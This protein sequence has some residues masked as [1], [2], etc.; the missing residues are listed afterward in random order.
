MSGHS[1][2]CHGIHPKE[3]SSR[4]VTTPLKTNQQLLVSQQTYWYRDI[5]KGRH[6]YITRAVSR[7][8]LKTQ[9]WKGRSQ[10]SKKCHD[11]L[12]SILKAKSS[13]ECRDYITTMPKTHMKGNNVATHHLVGLH[14][15]PQDLP[16]I[17][18]Q[19]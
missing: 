17:P 4:N 2:T 18:A 9:D 6:L 15:S 5:F 11:S 1:Q 14:K 7:Q 10:Q 13:I 19:Q 8:T 16:R 12:N 3:L